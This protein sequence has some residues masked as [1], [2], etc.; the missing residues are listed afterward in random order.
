MADVVIWDDNW[1]AGGWLPSTGSI[2]DDS[3][4]FIH[5][6][7]SMKITPFAMGLNVGYFYVYKH[8]GS[9]DLSA[10]NT[11]QFWWY[12]TG[13]GNELQIVFE[14][15]TKGLIGNFYDSPAE[16]TL[17]TIFKSSMTP[18]SGG[19]IDW[20]DVDLIAIMG[21][22]STASNLP[23]FDYLIT[24][25]VIIPTYTL[26]I[27]APVGNGTTDPAPSVIS[28][29]PL[30]T[31][32]T[33]TATASAGYIFGFWRYGCSGSYNNPLDLYIDNNF[34]I[35]P[36]FLELP[37]AHG[38]QIPM[39]TYDSES[40]SG[41]GHTTSRSVM[42]VSTDFTLMLA[43]LG[44][45]TNRVTP[46]ITA[47]SNFDVGVL[48]LHFDVTKDNSRVFVVMMGGY[49]DLSSV[50]KQYNE[51]YTDLIP[52][53]T[54]SDNYE[55]VYIATAILDAGTYE[56]SATASWTGTGISIA[57]YVFPPNTVSDYGVGLSIEDKL[58]TQLTLGTSFDYFIFGAA[59]GE[60]AVEGTYE[61][62]SSSSLGGGGA[63][64]IAPEPRIDRRTDENL[65]ALREAK[66]RIAEQ[67]EKKFQSEQK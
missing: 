52:L 56:V 36:T 65:K 8:F 25:T 4:N 32:V 48:D 6:T 35:T 27:E 46:T 28:D 67:M 44:I 60:E 5:G 47:D 49:Y 50:Y 34:T 15:G 1:I 20:A 12:G 41:I 19:A 63:N 11:I 51:K 31:I 53:T 42:A 43:G 55:S 61:M 54:G 3:V 9:I 57:V 58:W 39:D 23:E 26:T 66:K 22:V 45:K 16:W 40:Y 21:L 59:D 13:T 30:G 33:L 17:I 2:E 37:P 18:Y 29:I 14:N 38:A 24:S 7:N 10:N 64:V 62:T